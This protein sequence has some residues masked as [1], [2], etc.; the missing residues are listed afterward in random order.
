MSTDTDDWAMVTRAVAE[1]IAERPDEY[2]PTVR[3]NLED[4]L[5]HIRR[6]NR[7]APSVSPGYWPTF[8]LEWDVVESSNLLIEV[9]EDRY[10]VYRFF[11]GK[12]DIWYEPHAHGD[13][14]SVAFE[15]E[16]PRAA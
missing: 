5:L 10:E 6:T 7:P 12:T 4:L 13:R 16:L 11:D 14:L 15:A 1:I 8:C 2:L 3:Q 9:F